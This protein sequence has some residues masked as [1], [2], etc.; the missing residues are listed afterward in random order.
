MGAREQDVGD[1]S[2][3]IFSRYVNFEDEISFRE[4]M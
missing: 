1:S 3:V 4:E 2:T